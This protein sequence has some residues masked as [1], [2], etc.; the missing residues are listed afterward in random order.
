MQHR[1]PLTPHITP[2]T[3]GLPGTSEAEKIVG[4][5]LTFGLIAAVAGVA[6]SAIAWALGSH[7]AN[8]HLSGRGKT[9]VIVS[10]AAAVLVG[11]ADILISFFANAGASLS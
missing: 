1:F 9:G 2:N 11:G 4:A 6:M 3:N 7:S 5:L 8:P 10:C